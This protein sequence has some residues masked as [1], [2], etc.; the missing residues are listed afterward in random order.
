[1]TWYSSVD[2]RCTPLETFIRRQIGFPHIRV[3]G[4]VPGS[5][6]QLFVDEAEDKVSTQTKPKQS[7]NARRAAYR[8]QRSKA[9]ETTTKKTKDGGNN[10]EDNRKGKVIRV[11]SPEELD[12]LITKNKF[13]LPA[14]C[15]GSLLFSHPHSSQIHL[16]RKQ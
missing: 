14:S 16:N 10:D 5:R 6:H 8:N 7:R 12:R 11:S 4:V 3:L 2:I 1:M 13:D 9:N 15:T